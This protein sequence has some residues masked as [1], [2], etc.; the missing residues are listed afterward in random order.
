MPEE[1]LARKIREP[2]KRSGKR[3][4]PRTPIRGGVGFGE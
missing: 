4:L 2:I 1:R 3:R